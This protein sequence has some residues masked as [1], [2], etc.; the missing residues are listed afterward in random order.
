MSVVAVGGEPGGSGAGIASTRPSRAEL[1]A[2][3]RALRQEWP[4]VAG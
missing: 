3:G 1:R 2:R 4:P